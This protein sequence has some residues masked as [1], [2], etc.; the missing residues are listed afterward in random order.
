MY[1]N[2]LILSWEIY[3]MDT[4]VLI[5]SWEIYVIDTIVLILF[6]GPL[7]TVDCS[8]KLRSHTNTVVN[9][10]PVVCWE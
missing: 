3:L 10:T 7:L 5:L 4:H 1:T 8:A 9:S 6:I 2:V